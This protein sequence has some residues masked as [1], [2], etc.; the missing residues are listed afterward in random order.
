MNDG[1]DSQRPSSQV[2]IIKRFI[3]ARATRDEAGEMLQM[4]Y[5][6]FS[7]PDVEILSV[8]F[9]RHWT[10]HLNDDRVLLIYCTTRMKNV[11]VCKRTTEIS[12]ISHLG[13]LHSCNK[14]IVL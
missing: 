4:I 2:F 13:T 14:S 11:K 10:P 6:S 9:W 7:C 1:K 8:E 12:E 5:L 3:F